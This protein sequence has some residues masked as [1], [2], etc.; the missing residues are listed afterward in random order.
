[1]SFGP[2]TNELVR[3]W[4]VLINI[5]ALFLLAVSL[6]FT[7]C[8]ALEPYSIS[9]HPTRNIPILLSAIQLN[10]YQFTVITLLSTLLCSNVKTYKRIYIQ[11]YKVFSFQPED[12]Q[13][14]DIWTFFI[15]EFLILNFNISHVIAYKCSSVFSSTFPFLSL[16]KQ[17]EQLGDICF[18]LRYVPTAGK[19]TVVILEAKN[20]KKMDV[21][22]LSGNTIQDTKYPLV[23]PSL[24]IHFKKTVIIS[25]N[26]A[27]HFISNINAN[28]SVSPFSLSLS[29][30]AELKIQWRICKHYVCKYLMMA[31]IDFTLSLFYIYINWFSH[32]KFAFEHFAGGRTFGIWCT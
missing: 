11:I 20:L 31:V 22:G 32:N 30:S 25:Y 28:N 13:T 17:Q 12:R 23:F 6:Q 14:L 16:S 7:R 3:S 18:S 29:C 26:F 24:F 27:L 1:M 21:G 5:W 19:L 2:N 9:Q 10:V 4:D 15:F 8:D